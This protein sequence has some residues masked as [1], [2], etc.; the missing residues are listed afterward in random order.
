MKPIAKRDCK[1]NDTY[2]EK[3]E[4]IKVQTIEQLRKLNERGFIEPLTQKEIQ[5]YFKKSEIK[6]I[7]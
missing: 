4:E 5:D 6:K 1:I 2:Y 7:F 3:G